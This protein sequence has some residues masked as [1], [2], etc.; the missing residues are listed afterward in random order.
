[1][2]QLPNRVEYELALRCEA[3]ATSADLILR[4]TR[5]LRLGSYFKHKIYGLAPSKGELL[6]YGG[7]GGE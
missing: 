6:L 5:I 7:A 2:S 1:M 3:Q 4:Y